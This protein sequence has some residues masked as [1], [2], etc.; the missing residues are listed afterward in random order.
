MSG[1]SM[2]PPL[3]RTATGGDV[4][5]SRRASLLV[6]GVFAFLTV[7]F[8]GVFTPW[9]NPNELSRFEAVI[10][11]AEWN[12]FSIDR[13]IE[14]LGDH[15]DK[16][17]A[18][19]HF[20]SNKAP[21]LGFAAYPV[22]RVLR[23][24]LPMPSFATA[25]AIFWLMRLFTVSVVC[26]FALWRFSRRVAE[27]ATAPW[28]APLVT[29]AVGMGTTYLFYARS[30][31][32]HAWTAALLFLSW[33]LI[34]AAEASGARRPRLAAA[35]AG[36][37]AALAAISEYTVAP[38]AVLLALRVVAGRSL[39]R[40]AAFGL[41]ALVP[42]SA[43]LV[44][45]A[46]CFGSPLTLSSALEADPSY[47][48]LVQEGNFGFR[49]P[50]PKFAAYYLFHPARGV[51]VFSPF[52]LWAVPGAVRWWRSRERR[53][54]WWFFVGGTGV[55][56][57]AMSGYPNWHGGWA[58]GSRYLVPA[59]FLAAM[60]VAYALG[61]ALSRGLFLAATTFSVANHLVLTSSCV[62]FPKE[63][64][65]PAATG[66][67]WLLR[68]GWFAE[69]LG[70]AAG[71]PGWIS[72]LLPAALVVAALLLV[73]APLALAPLRPARS[74]AM[75]LGAALLV[76]LLL[77]PPEPPYLGR[78]WRAAVLGAFTDRDLQR[79]ELLTVASEASTP[80][81]RALAYRMW[82]TYGPPREVRPEAPDVPETPE[83]PRAP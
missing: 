61:S 74:V 14:A 19:G 50:S 18:N 34:R 22:Y 26:T 10:S 64:P 12:T 72:V 4:R 27:I 41:A 78:L 80:G 25:N 11:M 3:A 42:L 32:S 66:S 57:V 30:F 59:V 7:Y 83:K 38:I 52:L 1:V 53:A 45:N 73:S 58:L 29:L 35:G 67:L 75:L 40:A 69:N 46:V 16:S 23:L 33:D 21:G 2:H 13:A 77:R 37:L 68:H 60:P 44:Y 54:D 71:L 28:V 43:L 82:R 24:G 9:A 55:L 51:L 79:Q 62:Y 63:M 39:G 81:E 76:A 36:L 70:M 8:R 15:E 5:W 48:Q 20:Y 47:A 65:W 56:L 49:F 6:V 17:A 31:F